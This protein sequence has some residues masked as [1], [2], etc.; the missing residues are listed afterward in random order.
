MDSIFS[1]TSLYHVSSNATRSDFVLTGL[2]V[3]HLFGWYHPNQLA[4]ALELPKSALYTHLADWSLEQWKKFL[5]SRGCHQA[6]EPIKLTE[7]MSASTQS[8]RRMTIG[9]DDTVMDRNGK[10]LSDCYHGYSGRFHSVIN[11]H[12]IIAITL[13]IGG[14]VVPLSVRFVGKQGRKNTQKPQIFSEMM[15]QVIF[16]FA[17]QISITDDPIT[18]DSWIGLNR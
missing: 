4:D 15:Q 12:S 9:V 8:R 7:S 2:I 3:G 5:F 16:W 14:V 11:G 18:F 13:K 10:V 17:H 6:I 1:R